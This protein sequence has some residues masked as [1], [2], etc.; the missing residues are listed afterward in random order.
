M[1]VIIEAIWMPAHQQSA[2][3]MLDVQKRVNTLLGARG[4][5]L[6]L[7]VREIGWKLTDLGLP[8]KRNA[9]GMFLKFSPALCSQIHRLAQQFELAL[10]KV[11][12]C[13]H[14]TSGQVVEP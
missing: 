11:D 9:Q 3:T 14:C 6:E 8:R 1:A 5:P 7:N 4:Q 10:R 13:T 2:I 12:V